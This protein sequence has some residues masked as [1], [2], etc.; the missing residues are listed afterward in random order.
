MEGVEGHSGLLVVRRE[1]ESQKSSR[2]FSD[3]LTVAERATVAVLTF[4]EDKSHL[5]VLWFPA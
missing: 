5:C 3:V 2:R 4:T 1:K